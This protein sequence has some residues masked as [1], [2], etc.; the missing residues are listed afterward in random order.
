MEFLLYLSPES[1]DIYKM[2]SRKVRVVE[3]T[4]ICRQNDIFGFYDAAK[5]KFSI[6]IDKIKTYGNLRE[7]VTETFLHESVHVAQSCKT[8]GPYL[9]PLGISPSMMPL[10][11]RRVND[12]KKTVTSDSRL[13]YIDME[14]YW[15]EDKPEKVRYVVQKYCF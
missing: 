2:V 8:R 3:N 13:K 15:M 5:K 4:P 12:L 14:A 10:N 7:Y 1:M 6:C 11:Q 9:E